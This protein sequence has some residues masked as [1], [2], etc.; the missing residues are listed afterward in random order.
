[1]TKDDAKAFH[2]FGLAAEQKH[3]GA[4]NNLGV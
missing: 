4:N 3:A 2:Y 1:V